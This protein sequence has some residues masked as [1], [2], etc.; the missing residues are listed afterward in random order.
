MAN[1][2]IVIPD[3]LITRYETAR[4]QRTAWASKEG[5][6]ITPPASVAALQKMVKDWMKWNILA[7]AQRTIKDPAALEALMI[8][9]E[10]L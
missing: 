6:A 9:L 5:A 10:A 8:E 3:L 2:T 4:V 1:I 7:E